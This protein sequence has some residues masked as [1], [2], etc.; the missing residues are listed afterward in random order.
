MRTQVLVVSNWWSL[1]E[2]IPGMWTILQLQFSSRYRVSQSMRQA[3]MLYVEKN[4]ESMGVDLQ[5]PQGGGRYWSWKSKQH[6][7]SL[8][9]W[10]HRITTNNIMQAQNS[11]STK[12]DS[13]LKKPNAN[14]SHIKQNIKKKKKIQKHLNENVHWD[15]IGTK[16]SV[17][18]T[19]LLMYNS[20][21]T[22]CRTLLMQV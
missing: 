12:E 1:S 8:S 18:P 6:M 22:S 9:I 2:I 17:T 13:E 16:C 4:S 19:L 5:S 14:V 10:A 11:R 20:K 15:S 7:F 21:Q 3:V